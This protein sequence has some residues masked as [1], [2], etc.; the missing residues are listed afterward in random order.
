MFKKPSLIFLA[1]SVTLYIIITILLRWRQER[2]IFFPDSKIKSTPQE[3]NLDYQDVWFDV[4]QDKIH[5]WWIP[6]AQ[7]TAPALL[8]FHGNASNNGDLTEIAAIFHS[9]GLGV[10]IIDYRG[11]GKSSPIFPNETRVYQDAEAAWRY[12][13]T[14][15]LFEPQRTFVYG[16]SL[17]GAIAID[18]ASKHPDMAGLIVEGTF[19]SMK[20]MADSIPFLPI[21]PLDWLITQRFDSITKIKVVETPVLILHGRSD[22]TIPVSMANRLYAAAP[23]PKQLVIIDQANHD[24]LPEFGGQQYRL[25]LKQFIN[26]VINSQQSVIKST[27]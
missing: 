15:L 24:N 21:F 10:L 9:L 4:E 3:Y 16:H 20:D 26:S 22:R 13:T 1:I 8:Y 5:G 25:R 12:L 18:L 27:K 14:E 11:Y 6:A 2:L 23:E 7:T 17:G 19:T